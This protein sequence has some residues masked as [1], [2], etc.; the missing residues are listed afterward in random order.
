MKT[1]QYL[2]ILIL[3][4]LFVII[5][6]CDT[7]IDKIEYMI[8]TPKILNAKWKRNKCDHDLFKMTDVIFKNHGIDYADSNGWH[9]YLPCTY[10]FISREINNMPISDN[11]IYFIIDNIDEICSKKD[12]WLNIVGTYGLKTAC[13]LS[14]RTYVA[15]NVLDMELLMQNHVQGNIYIMKKNV[16]RQKGL[17]ITNDAKYIMD[18]RKNYVVVQDLLQNPYLINKRK[19][20]MR[21]YILVLCKRDKMDVYIFNNGFMYYTKEHFV[22]NN[23]SDDVNITTGYV[24]RKIYK[25]NPLTHKDFMNYLDDP[26]R[27]LNETEKQLRTQSP[28]NDK[29]ISNYLTYKIHRLMSDVFVCFKDKIGINPKLHNNL[30]FQLFGADIGVSDMLI[31]QIIEVNK[32]PDLSSKDERDKKLKYNMVVGMFRTVGIINTESFIKMGCDK[33]IRLLE[34]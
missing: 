6:V 23:I 21:I 31:P 3:C 27:I 12:L 5:I 10:N 26:N 30:K 29:V 24:D 32:G 33:F 4:L 1:I 19:I 9:L 11:G 2:V 18:N 28:N 16:Q 17:H 7:A 22:K 14:P 8:N 20:N 34:L 15:G 13:E 25:D